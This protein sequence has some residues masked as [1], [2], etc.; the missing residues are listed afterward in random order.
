MSNNKWVSEVFKSPIT[1]GAHDIGSTTKPFDGSISCVQFYD[2]VLDPATIQLKK[3]CPDL[4]EEFKVSPCLENYFH[5]DGMCYKISDAAL[6]Y[7]KAEMLCLPETSSD[8]KTQLMYSDNP[9]TNEYIVQKVKAQHG[10]DSFW[11]G[12]SDRD[13]DTFYTTSYG[14]NITSSDKIFKDSPEFPCGIVKNDGVGHISTTSCD[15]ENYFVCSMKPLYAKPDYDCPKGFT[16]YRGKC[17]YPNRVVLNYASAQ[18]ECSRKGSIILPLKDADFQSFITTW[19]GA[20]VGVDTWV[21]LRKQK[22][23]QYYDSDDSLPQPLQEMKTAEFTYA[24]DLP[25]DPEQDYGMGLRKF[26]TECYALKASDDFKVNGFTCTKEKGF[27]CLWQAFECPTGYS[28]VNKLS[29]GK[30][31]HGTSD[32]AKFEEATCS[33]SN[34]LLRQSWMPK[35]SHEFNLFQLDYVKPITG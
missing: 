33:H 17:L 7:E 21:G 31:C 28:Y 6:T 34:D 29:N 24:D 2:Y 9:K 20:S 14:T 15:S 18:L 16:P 26:E 11:V 25:F 12:I 5:Y 4:P 30:T 23:S 19:A 22:W 1:L 13:V 32:A 8:Y 27:I 35:N 3:N 10:E